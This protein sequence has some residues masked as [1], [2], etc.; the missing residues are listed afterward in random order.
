MCRSAWISPNVLV[1]NF[2]YLLNLDF[3][4]DVVKILFS[5]LNIYRFCYSRL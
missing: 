2:V 1:H 3:Y 4:Y 5:V